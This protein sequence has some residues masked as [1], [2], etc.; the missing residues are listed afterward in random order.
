MSSCT[1]Y[2][3]E[4]GTLVCGVQVKGTPWELAASINDNGDGTFIP[5]CVQV[6]KDKAYINGWYNTNATDHP[7]KSEPYCDGFLP[8]EICCDIENGHVIH[9]GIYCEILDND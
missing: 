5:E 3:A 4:D 8:A 7:Y 1:R 9:A 6:Y 2:S